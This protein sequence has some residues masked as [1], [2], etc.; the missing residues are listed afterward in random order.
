MDE[1]DDRVLVDQVSHVAVEAGTRRAHAEIGS[2][3]FDEH[4]PALGSV[5]ELLL[6][7]DDL[8]EALGVPLHSAMRLGEGLHVLVPEFRE[9]VVLG[10]PHLVPV[11]IQRA[12]VQVVP[13][14]AQRPRAC[15]SAS[16]T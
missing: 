16:G 10:L 6:V 2:A 7:R 1:V 8:G 15:F 9:D 12:R 3:V 14:V 4:D 11:E 5:E 13:L